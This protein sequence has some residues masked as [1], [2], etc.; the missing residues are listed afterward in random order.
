MVH[1]L[2]SSS[3]IDQITN[4]DEDTAQ[5]VLT[6]SVAKASEIFFPATQLISKQF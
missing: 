6:E 5:K 4:P 3:C 1:L 2:L